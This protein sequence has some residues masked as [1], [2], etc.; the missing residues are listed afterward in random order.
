MKKA[1]G[2]SGMETTLLSFNLKTL[3]GKKNNNT[4]KERRETQG[5]RK[6]NKKR[7]FKFI[8]NRFL[9]PPVSFP[10]RLVW[11]IFLN[12]IPERYYCFNF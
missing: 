3:N 10:E 12:D 5:E 1:D 7:W 8:F 9:L 6:V 4:K 11:M 2:P